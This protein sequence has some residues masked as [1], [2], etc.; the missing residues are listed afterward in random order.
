[1]INED[2]VNRWAFTTKESSPVQLIRIACKA[3]HVRGSDECGVASDFNAFLS[4]SNQMSHF[5]SFIGN[6]FNI[7]FYTAA[8]FYFHMESITN[9]LETFP[10]QNHLLKSVGEFLLTLPV[11]D[12]LV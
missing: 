2:H 5:V 9:F 1:M 11:F 6:R 10:N 12:H 8:A 3:F 4:E 7:L